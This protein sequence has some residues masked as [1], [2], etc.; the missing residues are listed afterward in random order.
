MC[1][2]ASPFDYKKKKKDPPKKTRDQ[3]SDLTNTEASK[4][5]ATV[6]DPEVSSVPHKV[7]S[8][9]HNQREDEKEKHL[10]T[11]TPHPAYLRQPDNLHLVTAVIPHR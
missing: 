8:V 10:I 2:A 9:P 3:I 5:K 11:V 7:S 6:R 4:Q 1:N